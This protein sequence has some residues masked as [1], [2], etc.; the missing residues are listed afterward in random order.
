MSVNLFETRTMMEIVEEGR[1][2]N[3]SVLRDTF[4]GKRKMFDTERIDFDIVGKGNRK[5]A[6]FVNPKIGGKAVDRQGYRTLS[7]KTPEV[8]PEMITTAEDLLKRRPGEAYFGA[9]SPNQ[10]AAEQLG[11]DL[12]YLDEIITRRE[13]AMC[14]EALFEGKV[15]VK[16]DGYN[17]VIEYWDGDDSPVD[18]A[19]WLSD[20]YTLAQIRADLRRMGLDMVK[21]GGAMPVKLLCGTNVLNAIFAKMEADKTFDMSRIFT[22]QIAPKPEK[23]GVTTHGHFAD[24]GLDII[25]YN[26]WYVNDSGVEV[27]FV[28]ENK[29][30]LVAPGADTVMAYGLVG[31]LDEKQND[32][33]LYA[34]DRVPS[35]WVQRKNPCGRVVQIKSAP[36][37]I[38]R[39]IHDFRV[40]TATNA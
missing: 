2:D 5:I 39:R 14:A 11:E 12:R 27:P 19:L 37:P 24:A 33:K 10:R 7:Y 38:I 6:P 21:N 23:I 1:K 28:P 25:S 18:T 4:F 22:G 35:S 34:G 17:D 16:G 8:S 15:T 36:L 32:V 13:E 3:P 29:A 26:G 40:I 9:K 30:L 20:S 31:I